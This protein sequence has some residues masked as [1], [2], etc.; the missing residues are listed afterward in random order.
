LWTGQLFTAERSLREE[1]LWES[2]LRP[3]LGTDRGFG[4]VTG[5]GGQRDFRVI[6]LCV[7]VEFK[8]KGLDKFTQE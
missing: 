1:P 4:R 5:D 7:C 3:P 6:W 2:C 8:V